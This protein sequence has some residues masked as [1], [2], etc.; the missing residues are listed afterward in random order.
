[1]I[2]VQ[3]LISKV[4][5]GSH[6]TSIIRSRQ[7]HK[8]IVRVLWANDGSNNVAIEAPI[9]TWTVLSV[10]CIGPVL[11]IQIVHRQL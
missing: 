8:Q 4:E 5:N 3:E 2:R 11:Q 7:Q 9:D 10:Q 6:I 1:M